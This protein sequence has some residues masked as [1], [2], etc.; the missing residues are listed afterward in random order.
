MGR[1]PIL[2]PSLR[3]ARSDDVE[4]LAE[5]LRQSWLTVIGPSVPA[6]LPRFISEDPAA[7]YAAAM[8]GQFA[9][10]EVNGCIAGMVHV[11]ENAVASLHVDSLQK[12]CGIGSA[13]MNHAERAIAE[14][15]VEARLEVL[16]FNKDALG[17]YKR[18]GWTE[19]RRISG[20]EYGAPVELIEMRKVVGS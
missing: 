19:M 12:R 17:F 14:V 4:A 8:W 10:A 5:L 11:H 18:R 9:V 20:D 6:A 13:L 1:R 16:S 3:P 2:T 7:H 15:A